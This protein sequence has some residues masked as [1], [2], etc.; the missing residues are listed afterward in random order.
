LGRWALKPRSR[1]KRASVQ[2]LGI[3][4]LIVGFAVSF[5]GYKLLEAGF[6]PGEYFLDFSSLIPLAGG[7]VVLPLGLGL[8]VLGLLALAND[9]DAS[10]DYADDWRKVGASPPR[11]P[12]DR[13]P[14]REGGGVVHSRDPD[15]GL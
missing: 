7:I 11:E 5:A 2:M 13:R 4:F 8:F 1:S 3:V 14:I 15:R 10:E 6:A 9:G 12:A